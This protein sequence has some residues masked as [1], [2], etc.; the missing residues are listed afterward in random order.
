VWQAACREEDIPEPGDYVRYDIQDEPLVIVRLPSGEVTGYYN[1]CKHRGRL[2]VDEQRGNVIDGMACKFHGWRWGVDGVLNRVTHEQ[3]WRACAAL[4]DGQL[5]LSRPRVDF[6]GGWV[7]VNL[8]PQ[9]EPLAEFLGPVQQI[10]KNFDLHEMRYAWYETVISPVNWKVFVEA[11]NEGYHVGETHAGGVDHGAL[12]TSVKAL[13][14]HSRFNENLIRDR[15]TAEDGEEAAVVKV[16]DESGQLVIAPGQAEVAYQ[17]GKQLHDMLH[18]L[19]SDAKLRALDR[20]RKEMPDDAPVSEVSSR[21]RALWREEV[22]ASGARWPDALTQEDLQNAGVNF[23]IFPN[24]IMLPTYDSTLVF[25]I[26]PHPD[27]DG[28]CI[29]DVGCLERFAPGKEPV[30]TP[31]VTEGF[32][33]FRGRNP[34]LD[35]DLSNMTGVQKGMKSRSFKGAFLNPVQECQ[36]N[37]FHRIL[38]TYIDE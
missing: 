3:D 32:D 9:A 17:M 6:W 18:A 21:T 4:S 11:F 37:H 7:W 16:R 20:V 2:L 19:C 1:V 14:L 29:M 31:L 28:K 15:I 38:H 12:R 10:F 8:N 27:D 5:D 33:A 23:H 25:R 22:E 13:G 26:R 34:F 35:Q 36:I 24:L 30:I